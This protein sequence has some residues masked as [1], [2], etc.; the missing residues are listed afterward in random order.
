MNRAAHK[1]GHMGSRR[2]IASALLSNLSPPNDG[3]TITNFPDKVFRMMQ[4]GINMATKIPVSA[5]SSRPMT[6]SPL[7][8]RI[9]KRRKM[10]WTSLAMAHP[11]P[12][13]RRIWRT[14]LKSRFQTLTAFF[15]F[16][17]WGLTGFFPKP[18]WCTLRNPNSHVALRVSFS[19][20]AVSKLK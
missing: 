18:E 17:P 19:D 13:T 2:T 4:T 3:L 6:N 15:S 8:S 16:L 1:Q 12:F 10:Q 11:I 14:N 5:G 7:R 20:L 9:S